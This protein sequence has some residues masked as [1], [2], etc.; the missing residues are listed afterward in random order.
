VHSYTSHSPQL[1]Q[2]VPDHKGA[3]E[4]AI[5]AALQ[6]ATAAQLPSQ[7]QFPSEVA[8]ATA[9]A[10]QAAAGSVPL[11]LQ[12]FKLLHGRS[13]AVCILQQLPQATLTS[14]HLQVRQTRRGKQ[15]CVQNSYYRQLRA[16]DVKTVADL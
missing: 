4:A 3:A 9:A 1:I 15:L 16:L 6:R 7:P 12:A 13:S 5:A 10:Q 14:L 2:T 11:P 8:A